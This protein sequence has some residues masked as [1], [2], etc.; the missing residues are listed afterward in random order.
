MFSLWSQHEGVPKAT[1]PRLSCHPVSEIGPAEDHDGA[2]RTKGYEEMNQELPE[3]HEKHWVSD[4][5]HL[6]KLLA[7]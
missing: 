4:L 2:H 7:A 6:Q 5:V 3:V 1:H